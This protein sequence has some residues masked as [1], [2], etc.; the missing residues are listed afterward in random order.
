[1]KI[2]AFFEKQFIRFLF[3]GGVNTLFGYSVF[4]LLIF[5]R[6][7]YSLASLFAT[8]LGMLFNFQT[9]G[10]FVFASHNQKLLIKFLGVYSFIY[11]LNVVSLYF[12]NLKGVSNYVSGAI[13]IFPMALVSFYLNKRF[14]FITT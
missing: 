11:I 6:L 12:F 8:I 3:I 5:L 10:R 1:M 13:L 14:V 2:K 9:V 4:A 7:H